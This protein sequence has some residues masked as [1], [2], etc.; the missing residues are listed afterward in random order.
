MKEELIEKYHAYV[1]NCKAMND[2]KVAKIKI[3]TFASLNESMNG[4]AV[5][6]K[7]NI[8][9]KTYYKQTALEEIVNVLNKYLKQ[10]A[11]NESDITCL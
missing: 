5:A 4:L 11:S 10:A 9:M 8:A 1:E 2:S 7:L 6:P 3:K